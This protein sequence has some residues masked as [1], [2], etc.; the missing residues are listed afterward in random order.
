MEF[1]DL[2]ADPAYR[3]MLL[4]HV[5]IIGLAMAWIGLMAGLILRQ[6]PMVM[7]GLILV[8]LGA[9]SSIPAE[10]YGDA[11]YPAI[12]D[13]LD[14][15]G[16]A[17]LDHHANL[18]ATWMPVLY[19]NCG[20]AVIAIGVALLRRRALFATAWL[21]ALVTLAGIASAAYIA[22]AGGK[23]AHPEFRIVDPP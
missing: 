21:V 13:T 1:F 17:W 15:T 23:I 18:A 11:A 5:P 2:L 6:R 7:L 8:A 14:G 12:Y 19:I 9:G 4:N 3:H 20:L 16:R 10:H 22:S